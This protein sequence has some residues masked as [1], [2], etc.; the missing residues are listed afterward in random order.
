[1]YTKY[2]G[3]SGWNEILEHRTAIR[4]ADLRLDTHQNGKIQMSHF[5]EPHWP[6]QDFFFIIYYIKVYQARSLVN[7][8]HQQRHC[9]EVFQNKIIDMLAAKAKLF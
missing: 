2:F 1:M 7:F 3:L 6:L 8:S 9:V 4:T 5:K